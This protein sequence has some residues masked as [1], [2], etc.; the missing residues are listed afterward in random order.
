MRDV[1]TT[2]RFAERHPDLGGCRVLVIGAGVSGAAAARLAASR[3]AKVTVADRRD[4]DALP[5]TEELRNAGIEVRGG[6]HPV[7]LASSADLVVISPG[8]RGDEPVVRACRDAGVPVWGEVELAARFCTGR[9]VGITGSNGKSTTTSM[10]GCI[11]RTAGVAGGTGGNLAVPLSDLL[12]EDAPDAV[13]A[14][15]LSSFQLES[16]E[17]F[18]ADVA[19]L[20]NLTPDHLDRYPDLDAYGRAKARLLETQSEEGDAILNAD[21]PESRR[22]E[23]DVRGRTWWFSTRREVEAGAFLRDGVLWLRAPGGDETV[24]EAAALPVRGE[25]NVAN[26]LAAALACRLVASCP[27]SALAAGLRAFRPL[28]HRLQRV[29]EIGG[30]A[31]Y[32]DSKATNVDAALRALES[33]RPGTVHLI[34]GGKDKGGD[35]DAMVGPVRRFA[36]RVLLVGEAA[37]AIAAALPDDVEAIDCGTVPA[38]VREGL[39]GA[40]EGDTV[41]LAPACASFDQYPNFEAR[42][43]HFREAVEACIARRGGGHGR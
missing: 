13:H 32:D 8:V 26:A 11:L 39:A 21:D 38:A 30:V 16:V 1:V 14:V 22:F 43:R 12:S 35:W 41:L 15:E 20:L 34:L 10:T 7:S 33:F 19:V 9:I 6:G 2:R 27:A 5:A 42:G 37:P 17:A 23:R 28:D 3:G 31:F 24:I 25:H 36:R 18:R 40:A 4:T 29:G